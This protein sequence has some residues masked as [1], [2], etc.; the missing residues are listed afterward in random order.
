MKNPTDD[1]AQRPN[2]HEKK[3]IEISLVAA[4]RNW[5]HDD[6]RHEKRMKKCDRKIVWNL[7]SIT[8]RQWRRRKRIFRCVKQA[9]QNKCRKHSNFVFAFCRFA[10]FALFSFDASEREGERAREKKNNSKSKWKSDW[11]DSTI[12]F[13]YFIF[14]FLLFTSSSFL[15]RNDA[16][17]STNLMQ[18]IEHWTLSTYRLCA[19]SECWNDESGN[20]NRGTDEKENP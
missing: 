9:E 10:L 2:E 8:R 20:G 13:F 14:C 19:I 1:Y 3:S 18:N 17:R 16:K 11:I 5:K 6:D 15:F 7:I 12:V 4:G